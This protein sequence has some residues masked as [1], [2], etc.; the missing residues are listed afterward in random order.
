VLLELHIAGI[1]VIEDLDLEFHPGL[2]VLTGETGAGK[3]MVTVGLTLALGGRAS[4]VLVRRGSKRAR[5]EA[6]FSAPSSPGVGEWAEDGEVVLARTVSEEGKS[7]ARIG[8]QI[9]PVSAL[10]AIAPE[11]VELHGQNQVQRLLEPG[12]QTGFLD[13]FAGPDHAALAEEYRQTYDRLRRARLR[14]DELDRE[15]RDRERE[16]DLL[17]YQVREIESAGVHVGELT[18][19]E[20][21]TGR[22]AHAERLLERA[23]VAEDALGAEG[24]AADRLHE[25]ASALRDAA[26]IDTSAAGAAERAA[27]LAQ[28]ASELARDA[29]AYREELRADPAR[30]EELQER[31]H[32]LRSLERK[33]GE[34]EDGILDYLERAR[35]RLSGLAGADNERAQLDEQ[36]AELDRAARTLAARLS[37]GRAEAA[38]RLASALEAELRELGM[39]GA[40]VAISLDRQEDLG[41]LGTDRAQLLF[42]GGPGQAPLPL[43]RVASGGEL[44]RSMLACRSVMADLDDVPTLVFDEVDAG[45]GGQAGLAVGRRLARLA[46][47]RQVLVVTHLPQIACFADRHIRVRK[48]EGIAAVSVLDPAERVAEISRMLSGLPESEASASHAEELLAEAERERAPDA[49]PRSLPLA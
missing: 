48:R 13:R 34:G 15:G 26:A 31:L 8:G 32:A 19:I 39:E 33:Y 30:L 14:L 36:A 5:V 4:A 27:N 11:L 41:P 20:A 47:T 38:P 35:A 24:G 37:D 25:T 1:G 45:I 42:S 6:R 18:G 22:L 9:V 21:E 44:S 16:K 29:R 17:A 49:G 40:S 46:R 12:A 23:R 10:A 28:E 2:S 3:T 7:A 43:S